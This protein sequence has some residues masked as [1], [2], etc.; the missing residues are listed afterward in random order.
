LIERGLPQGPEVAKTLQAIERRW[1]DA[2]FPRGQELDL[3]IN[4][5]L[6]AAKS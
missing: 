5:E 2:G 4:E 1:V 6:A 3:I